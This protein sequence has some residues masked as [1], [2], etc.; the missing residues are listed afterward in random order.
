ML[1]TLE[2]TTGHAR[3]VTRGS[4]RTTPESRSSRP[5]AS[6]GLLDVELLA[7]LLGGEVLAVGLEDVDER[8]ER[9]GAADDPGGRGA[10]VGDAGRTSRARPSGRPRRAG[11]RARR[12]RRRSA[13]PCRSSSHGGPVR[14]VGGGGPGERRAR[15]GGIDA[16]DER[17]QVGAVGGEPPVDLRGARDVP[18]AGDD[19]LRRRR[20][21][22]GRARRGSRRPGRRRRGPAAGSRRRRA[23]RRPGARRCRAGTGRCARG[24]APRA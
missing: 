17:R 20:T 2:A 12:H 16:R 22:A 5:A 9:A 18:V 14:G 8:S 13:I 24:R 4:S 10:L 15:V 6:A 3:P 11:V 19:D 21:R 7:V 1:G 23:C